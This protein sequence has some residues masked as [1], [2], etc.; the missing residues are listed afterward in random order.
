MN[1]TKV[2]LPDGTL[3]KIEGGNAE[4]TARFITERYLKN[5]IVTT[6]ARHPSQ[7]SGYGK[8]EALPVPVINWA[9]IAERQNQPVPVV[10]QS[11]HGE[12]PLPVAPMTFA[13]PGSRKR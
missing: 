10:V 1:T 9:K 2:E 8:E 3:V 6:Q 11:A 5:S 12:E 13:R 4:D 7:S